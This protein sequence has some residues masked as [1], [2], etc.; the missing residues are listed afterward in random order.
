MWKERGLNLGLV[1]ENVLTVIR[2]DEPI[3]LRVIEPLHGAAL[4]TTKPLP[5]LSSDRRRALLKVR[6]ST[7]VDPRRATVLSIQHHPSHRLRQEK[8]KPLHHLC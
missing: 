7:L 6:P 4:H 5:L 2:L 8:I 1:D 3:A